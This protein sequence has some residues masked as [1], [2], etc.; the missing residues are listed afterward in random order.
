[1]VLARRTG[2]RDTA[3]MKRSKVFVVSVVVVIV[4]IVVLA[5]NLRVKMRCAGFAGPG[6]TEAELPTGPPA[7]GAVRF[8]HFNLRNFPLDERP[9]TADL[10]YSRRTNICDL[11]DVLAGL[12]AQVLGFVEVCDT[13][14]FPPI[15]RR[16]GG[17]RSMRILFSQDGG[18]GG[19]HL[20]VAW[21]GGVFE[22]VEGP[23]EIRAI[24]V[25]PGLRPGLAVRL[26][27]RITPDFDFTVVEVHLDSG[28]GDLEYRLD[29][30]RLLGEWVAEWIDA[31]GDPD[32]VV[33]GDFNTMGGRNVSP[34][35]ELGLVDAVLE[36]AGLRRLDNATGCTQYWEG[37]GDADGL[38]QASLLDLVYLRGLEAAGP[39]RSWLHCDR[40]Q[41][42][43]LVSRPGRED[44]TFFDVSDHCPVTFE[45]RR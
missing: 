30:V 3:E 13:R 17:G 41:C 12:D 24:V 33:Q 27:S 1:M 19:Q 39:A 45:V 22:L 14:R 29:Q 8:A 36:G 18:G 25:K 16:A 43:E 21:D 40:L 34:V 4:G 37:P 9:Q 42:G 32:L 44:G 7:S 38:H 15:L 35:E 23:I 20:A 5:L 6:V 10:G 11:Q 28:R 26:R 31:T 2:A